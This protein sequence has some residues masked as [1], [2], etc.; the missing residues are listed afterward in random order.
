MPPDEIGLP[1]SAA[2]LGIWYALKV[3]QITPNYNLGGWTEI[4]GPV[5]PSLLETALGQAVND[6]EALRVRFVE[7]DDGPRQIIDSGFEVSLPFFDV[8]DRSD[9]T[10]AAQRWIESHLAEAIDPSHAGFSFALFKA[11]PDLFFWYQRYHHLLVDALGSLLFI[12]RV[13]EV[14]TALVDQ[15]PF[16]NNP[17]GPLE[18]AIAEDA[19][20][21]ASERFTNDRH[22]WL[23]LLAGR[24]EATSLNGRPPTNARGI[25]HQSAWV[26]SSI[27]KKLR[28]AG[29]RTTTGLAPVIMAATAIYLHRMTASQDIV[30]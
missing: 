19:A 3:D 23:D 8:S 18:R 15:R 20:Y 11:A 5:N 10:A 2:Q 28:S 21:R 27:V 30:I 12:R 6:T 9:P 1:L 25:L 14:Y 29:N 7:D 4:H 26:P 24:P 16:T 22:Y 17:F 13:A